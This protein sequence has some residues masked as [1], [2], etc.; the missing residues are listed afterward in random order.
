MEEK[1]AIL[2]EMMEYG[3][4][5]AIFYYKGL[6]N[7]FPEYSSSTYSKW[8]KDIYGVSA[9]DYFTEGGAIF[10]EEERVAHSKDI[11]DKLKSRYAEKSLPKTIIL[12]KKTTAILISI[13]FICLRKAWEFLTETATTNSLPI[14]AVLKVNPKIIASRAIPKP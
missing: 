4:N 10:T 8:V 1:M 12:L 5:N 13:I 7:A 14:T 9:V 3:R 2:D 11:F 6:T